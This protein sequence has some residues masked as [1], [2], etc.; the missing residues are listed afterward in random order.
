VQ[1]P[2]QQNRPG[3]GFQKAVFGKTT[4]EAVLTQTCVTCSATGVTAFR[5]EKAARE[6]HLSGMCQECQDLV[7][8]KSEE[9]E[10]EEINP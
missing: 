2:W 8:E 4:R 3:D 9:M 6:Y 10:K 7:F 1:Y 5:T